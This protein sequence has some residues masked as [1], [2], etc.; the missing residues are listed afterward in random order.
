MNVGDDLAIDSLIEQ[1]MRHSKAPGIQFIPVDYKS[2]EGMDRLFKK[3]DEAHVKHVYEVC[4]S[5]DKTDRALSR[6]RTLMLSPKFS[7]QKTLMKLFTM[8]LD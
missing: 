4:T 8:L 1:I 7:T 3:L 2:R 5:D 6:N